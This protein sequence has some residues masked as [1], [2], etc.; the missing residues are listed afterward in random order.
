[1][2]PGRIRRS[3]RG[4]ENDDEAKKLHLTMEDERQTRAKRPHTQDKTRHSNTAQAMAIED[5]IM[6]QHNETPN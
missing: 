6:R 4:E 5:N 1:M 2:K 3:A